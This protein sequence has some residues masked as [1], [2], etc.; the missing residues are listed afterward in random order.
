MGL[1]Y[2]IEPSNLDICQHIAYH[3]SMHDPSEVESDRQDR[4]EAKSMLR[5]LRKLGYSREM[6]Q[7]SQERSESD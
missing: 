2:N 7:G 5:R 6:Q 1:S 3:L 4:K